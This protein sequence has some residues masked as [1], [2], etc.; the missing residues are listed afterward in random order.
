MNTREFLYYQ[1]GD[2]KTTNK[3][4]AIEK[5]G[6]DIGR[7]HFYL[8]D[9][10]YARYD[11]TKEPTDDIDFL[12][13]QRVQLIREQNR[14]VC[15]W[16]SGGYDSQAILNSFIRTKTR[17][18][19]VVIYG[20]D[21]MDHATRIEDQLALEQIQQVKKLYQPWLNI[22]HIKYSTQTPVKFYKEHGTDW[23]YNDKGNFSQ[24]TKQARAN[25][26]RYQ[27][28]FTNLNHVFGRIDINGVDKPRV[29]LVDNRWYVQIPDV[30]LFHYF[31]ADYE[32]FFLNPDAAEIYIK[33]AWMAIRWFES[34][35]NCSHELVH[36]VQSSANSEI[37]AQW[38][39]AIG[40]PEVYNEIARIGL[41]KLIVSYGTESIE[42][43]KFK[44]Y[45]STAEKEAYD[46]WRKGI[47][48]LQ[49]THK[50]L[51]TPQKGFPVIMSKAIYIK[52]FEQKIQ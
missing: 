51:W 39:R 47:E 27:S 49:N 33:Q 17:L 18:D 24:F 12:I 20:R 26:A 28:D 7:V 42:S 48:Y 40:R 4:S 23:I 43:S 11:W 15:L 41:V 19:E 6:G 5:A 50:D 9:N 22:R 2:F 44:N 35:P 25:T 45:A 36:Q 29:N 10:E 46:T 34:L 8:A 37:F 38:N 31:D 3:L 16:Y 52:D 32:M 1:V 14:Y 21:W 30:S 13:D